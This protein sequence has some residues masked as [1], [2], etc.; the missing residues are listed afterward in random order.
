MSYPDQGE[1]FKAKN[2]KS[3]HLIFFAHFFQGHKKAL[4]RHIEFV[5][6]LGFDAYAFNLKDSPKE[7][8]YIPYSH[9]TKKFGMKH[10]LADQIDYHLDLLTEYNTKIIF[11]FSNVAGCAIEAV[12]RRIQAKKNDVI[13]MVCDSG[14]GGRFIYSSYKL[15]QEQL[16]IKSLPLKLINTPIVAFGWS[17]KLHKDIAADLAL[18]PNNFPLLSIRGWRDQLISPEHIDEIFEPHKN[19]KWKKLSLPE[20][21][22]LN[23]LRD[24]PSE[25]CPA[26]QNFLE[27]I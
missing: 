12:A 16:G 2:K 1:L 6:E 3:N 23:G 19:L 27:Q 24:F 17:P 22:H 26:V 18:F 14:P 20:A 5:N 9:I 10:A 11:V 21:G 25:Y 13:G 7:H 4:K 8:L 15:I